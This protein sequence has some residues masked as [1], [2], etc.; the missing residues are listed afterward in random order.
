[1]MGRRLG[2]PRWADNPVVAVTV[3]VAVAGQKP[4]RWGRDIGRKEERVGRLQYVSCVT[5]SDGS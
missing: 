5:I 1:M 4:L 2:T 3:A